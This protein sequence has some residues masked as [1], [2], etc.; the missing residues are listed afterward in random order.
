MKQKFY[1]EVLNKYFDTEKDCEDAEKAEA[2]KKT[3]LIAKSNEKKELALKVE[4]SYKAISEARKKAA[5]IYKKANEEY[6][7]AV[8]EANHLIS[9]A[10]SL[11]HAELNTFLE[12]H[13]EGFHTTI[14]SDDGSITTLDINNEGNSIIDLY[15]HFL[16][17]FFRF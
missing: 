16:D 5:D 11:Y 15:D 8:A 4:N 17:S 9:E 7:K 2:A 13:P 6:R 10:E 14:K 12:K 1:S 3:A